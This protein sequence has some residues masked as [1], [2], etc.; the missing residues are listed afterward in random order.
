MKAVFVNTLVPSETV[1]T[2][3]LVIHKEI[4]QKK[5]GEPYL[6]L[7]LG[8][9]TG[10]IEAKM[11]DN[12]AEVMNTFDRDD[13]VKVKG[14]PQIYQNKPQLTVH[15]IRRLEDHEVEPGDYFPCSRRDPEEMWAEL[16]GIV[17]S[18]GN[19]HLRLLLEAIFADSKIADL[20]KRAPAAKSIHHACLGGL[21]EHVLSLCALCRM[22]AAHYHGVDVDLLLT[23]AILHDIGKIEELAYERS[24]SY[25]TAGQLVGHIVMGVQLVGEKIRG[26]PGFPPKLKLLLEHMILSHHG[27]LEFGSPKVPVFP[28]ALLFHHLDNLDSKFESMRAAIE[29]DKH[30]DSEF[31]GWIPALERVVLKKERFLAPT[32][33]PSAAAPAKPATERAAPPPPAENTVPNEKPEPPKSAS[34]AEQQP[35]PRTLFGEKLQAVLQHPEQSE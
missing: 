8:D 33:E 7:L 9:R 29:R 17:G 12:V 28:E 27:S 10:E 25:T 2:H 14:L 15:K 22:T 11:W 4:R 18:L 21:I 3:F 24:F 13:F 20:Y 34:P 23:A 1:T 32:P 35:T 26:I 31:T 6:T 19:E 30:P 16:Q 5:T